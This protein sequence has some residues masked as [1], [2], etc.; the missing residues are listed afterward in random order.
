MSTRDDGGPAFPHHYDSGGPYPNWVSGRGMTL[1]DYFIAHAPAEPQ[2]WFKPNVAQRPET[3]VLLNLSEL[4]RFL[5][6]SLAGSCAIGDVISANQ[7]E[8][9]EWDRNYIKQLYIQ[10]PAAW[11]DE[12]L[13]AR[14]E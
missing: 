10:W 8:M 12:M 11:A 9:K 3:E 2:P 7:K 14:E 1:R 13:K 5:R 6:K 4:D